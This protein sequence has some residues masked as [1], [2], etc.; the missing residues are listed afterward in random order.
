MLK[1]NEKGWI[2]LWR[3]TVGQKWAN[4]YIKINKRKNTY[5]HSNKFMSEIYVTLGQNALTTVS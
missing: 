2:S 1:L 4:V 5:V 3:L